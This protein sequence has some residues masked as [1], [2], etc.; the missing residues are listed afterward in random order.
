V[1]GYTL[2]SLVALLAVVVLLAQRGLGWVALLPLLA[3]SLAVVA[4]WNSGAVVVVLCTGAALAIHARFRFAGFPRGGPGSDTGD[5]L[6][7]G[8]LLAYCAGQY[9]LLSLVRHIFP[10]DPRRRRRLPKGRPVVVPLLPANQVRSPDLVGASEQ[11]QLLLSVLGCTGLAAVTWMVLG[12]ATP[13]ADFDRPEWHALVL[14]WIGCAI[15]CLTW[16]VTG[17]LSWRRISPDESYLYLQDQLWRQTRREQSR[18]NRWLVWYR[19]RRQRHLRRRVK[20]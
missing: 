11:V 18:L 20:S 5:L 2:L 6:L 7:A 1:R 12:N 8:A 16:V 19:L 17:Y 13:P 4:Y 3:G 9:R 15:A 14:G 10:P